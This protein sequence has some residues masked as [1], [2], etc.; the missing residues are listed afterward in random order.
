[1]YQV[2]IQTDCNDIVKRIG[3]R[4]NARKTNWF[5]KENNPKPVCFKN[6]DKKVY[7]HWHG[8]EGLVA[9]GPAGLIHLWVGDYFTE[10]I[11]DLLSDILRGTSACFLQI[12]K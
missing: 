3:Y 9:Q 6:D 8:G 4:E 10:E 12:K 1:M 5:N 11:E 2:I 7:V